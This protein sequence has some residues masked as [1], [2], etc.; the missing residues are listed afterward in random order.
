VF[1]MVWL[2]DSGKMVSLSA[3]KIW[4]DLRP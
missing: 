1:R 3:F 4:D 2:V